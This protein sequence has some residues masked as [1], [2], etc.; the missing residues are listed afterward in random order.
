MTT[1]KK[2]MS[3]RPAVPVRRSSGV[4]VKP[5]KD[6]SNVA[7][8]QLLQTLRKALENHDP[9]Y[10]SLPALMLR[11]GPAS[12]PHLESGHRTFG[13]AVMWRLTKAF[14][15]DLS[16]YLS[17]RLDLETMVE[18]CLESRPPNSVMSP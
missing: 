10:W 13:D 11:E 16:D 9:R 6:P 15:V 1:A 14:H 17:G 2:Q 4:R 8:G 18:M 12:L 5:E 7:M 3:D